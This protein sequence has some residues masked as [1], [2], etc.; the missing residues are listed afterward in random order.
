MDW[1]FLFPIFEEKIPCGKSYLLFNLFKD[2]LLSEGVE[3]K[4]FRDPNVLSPAYDLLP[5]NA[6]MPAD[7][8]QF[9]LAMNG[10]KMNIRKGDFLNFSDICDIARP[11][12]EKMMKNLVNLTPKWIVMC[13]NSLLPDELKDRLKKIITERADVLK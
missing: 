9:A 12:A 10:K 5:V 3:S 2:P 4:Q 8:E 7:K 6:N 13:D 11:S 1:R